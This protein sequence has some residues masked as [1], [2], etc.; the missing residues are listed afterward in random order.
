MQFARRYFIIVCALVGAAWFAYV[1]YYAVNAPPG[2]GHIPT[3]YWVIIFVPLGL[4]VPLALLGLRRGTDE[5][6]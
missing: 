2:Y 6:D 1:F 3:A 4:G 5:T